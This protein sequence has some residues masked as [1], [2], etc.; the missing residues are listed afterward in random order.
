METLITSYVSDSFIVMSSWFFG[1]IIGG[2]LGAVA[3]EC[4]TK[5]LLYVSYFSMTKITYNNNF[6]NSRSSLVPWL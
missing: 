3:L 4:L 1:C 2:F 6:V 5:K